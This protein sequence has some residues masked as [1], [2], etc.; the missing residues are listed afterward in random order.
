MQKCETILFKNIA[1]RCGLTFKPP[2][3]AVA[4]TV[5]IIATVTGTVTG[6]HQTTGEHAKSAATRTGVFSLAIGSAPVA[7]VV[8]TCKITTDHQNVRRI[9][10][11]GDAHMT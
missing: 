3:L 5:I 1:N 7:D 4:G 9:D 11:S 6:K 10:A 2:S 8:I